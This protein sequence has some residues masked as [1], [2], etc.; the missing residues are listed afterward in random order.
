M[1]GLGMPLLELDDVF[2]SAC[3]GHLALVDA[4]EGAL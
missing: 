3:R 1:H 2:V 4:V